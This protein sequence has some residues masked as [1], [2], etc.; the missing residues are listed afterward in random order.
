MDM[1]GLVE[2]ILFLVFVFF[3]LAF[4]TNLCLALFGARFKIQSAYPVI[5]VI[6]GTV[7]GTAV[8]MI[9][10][11]FLVDHYGRWLLV[12]YPA[13]WIIALGTARLIASLARLPK[14][15]QA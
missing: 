9:A 10:A 12:A 2:M 3:I 13:G 4:V 7:L 14:N 5:A 8:T 11:F 15:R 1:G 6:T